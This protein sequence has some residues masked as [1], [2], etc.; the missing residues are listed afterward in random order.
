MLYLFDNVNAPRG[1]RIIETGTDA[2]QTRITCP[3]C[4][5][6]GTMAVETGTDSKTVYL[7]EEDLLH[8]CGVCGEEMDIVRPGKYQCPNCD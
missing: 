4:G 8:I 1:E 2:E 7:Y 6:C 3:Y 5:G